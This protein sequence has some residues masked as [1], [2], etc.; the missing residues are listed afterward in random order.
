MVLQTTENAMFKS[1]QHESL[2]DAS[3]A[4]SALLGDS[5]QMSRRWRQIGDSE[6]IE[7]LRTRRTQ[8]ETQQS[9]KQ[10]VPSASL[11]I[12]ALLWEESSPFSTMPDASFSPRRD[13]MRGR[14]GAS[15]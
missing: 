10:A 2:S 14:S 13:R 6:R 9:L 3:H 12:G 4:T 5:R 7:M 15:P 1:R 11:V 8:P